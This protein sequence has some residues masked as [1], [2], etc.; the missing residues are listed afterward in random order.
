MF[1]TYFFFFSWLNTAICELMFLAL[2]D[3][4][5]SFMLRNICNA[6]IFSCECLI[7]LIFFIW[8]LRNQFK[9]IMIFRWAVGWVG[10]WL[11]FQCFCKYPYTYFTFL[12]MF[13]FTYLNLNC[14]GKQTMVHSFEVYRSIRLNGGEIL[15]KAWGCST[16]KSLC[17]KISVSL[18]LLQKEGPPNSGHWYDT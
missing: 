6:A 7:C 8:R 18:H 11:Q 9:I 13:A 2:G 10:N 14:E 12:F 4:L 1:Y 5:V 15:G 16:I 17:S 3:L